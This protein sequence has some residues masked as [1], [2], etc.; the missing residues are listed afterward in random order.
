MSAGF[1]VTAEVPLRAGLLRI[2]AD[3][4]QKT[5]DHVLVLVAH[6]ITADGWSLRPL[7]RDVMTAYT[8]RAAGHAPAWTTPIVQY[9][10]FSCWQRAVLGSEDDPDSV[11]ATQIDYW[12]RVLAGLPQEST[13]PADRSRPA[14]ASRIGGTVDLTVDADT[15]HGLRELALAFQNIPTS[16]IG[17]TGLSASWEPIEAHTP[18]DWDLSLILSEE[19]DEQGRPRALYGLI[20]YADDIVDIS[21]VQQMVARFEA[22]LSAAVD[23]GGE[24]R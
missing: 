21:T 5:D 6:H 24:A 10:D 17:Q 2:D 19:K 9:A 1:D 11:A 15:T 22:I 23:A 8:A 18:A 14:A 16:D 4:G 3:A 20:E 7:I 12:R 13:F